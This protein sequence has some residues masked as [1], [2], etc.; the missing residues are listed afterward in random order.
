MNNASTVSSS[1]V[2]N[3]T[4][5]TILVSV[6]TLRLLDMSTPLVADT[7]EDIALTCSFDMEG[8]ELFA[9]KWYKDDHEFFR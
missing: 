7:R 1:K 8:E 2:H 3:L 5:K 4:K 6:D 9:V